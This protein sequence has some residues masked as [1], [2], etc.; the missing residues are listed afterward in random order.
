[1]RCILA[2]IVMGVVVAGC[3]PMS[4][5]DRTAPPANLAPPGTETPRSDATL[6]QAA[7]GSKL[8]AITAKPP[9]VP[10]LTAGPVPGWHTYTNAAWATAVDYPVDWS[11]TEGTGVV[12]FASPQGGKIQLQILHPD[13]SS[14]ESKDQQCAALINSH[15][16]DID[17]CFDGDTSTYSAKFSLQS[18]AG[19]TQQYLLST[20]G[21]EALDVYLQMI[22]SLRPLP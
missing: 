17:A 6:N 2:F 1:M 8:M 7:H 3:S 4:P 18:G 12:D 20:N 14:Q 5:A 10:V 22:D 19:S 15:G 16:M 13:D 11:V 9:M 21:K